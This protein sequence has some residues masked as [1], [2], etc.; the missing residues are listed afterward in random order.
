MAFSVVHV[1][2][3]LSFFFV[4]VKP[5]ETV[6]RSQFQHCSSSRAAWTGGLG[7]MWE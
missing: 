4:I 5:N 2:S 7:G 6:L 1:W 3:L